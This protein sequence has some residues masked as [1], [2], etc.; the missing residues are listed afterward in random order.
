MRRIPAAPLVGRT[1]HAPYGI[2]LVL[3]AYAIFSFVDT[4]AKWL[5]V[6]GYPALQLAFMR[7]AVHFVISTGRVLRAGRERSPLRSRHTALLVARGAF[8]LGGTVGNFVALTYIPLTLTSTILFSAPIIVCLLSGTLLGEPVGRRRWLA[9]LLGFGGILIAIRPFGAGFHWAALSALAGAGSFAFYLLLTRRFAGVIAPDALQF[10]S[11]LVGTLS[12]LPFA[13]YFWQ[14][15]QS[16]LDW[17]LLA[18][19]GVFAWGGHEV[20]IRAY[21]YADAGVL[22]PY[23]YSFIIYLTLWSI[24]LFDQYPDRWT[25]AGAALVVTSGWVIWVRERARRRSVPAPPG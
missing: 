24:V 2:G 21:R 10:Y 1:D 15:P 8:L 4:S 5:A 7:Y 16:P 23:S 9:I 25:L 20:L 13:V 3:I 19:L 6:I 11:G 18:G 14:W 17:A 22:T 12:M